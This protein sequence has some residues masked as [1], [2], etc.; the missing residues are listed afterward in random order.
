MR[1]AFARSVDRFDGGLL[2]A[3]LPDRPEYDF[4]RGDPRFKTLVAR[5]GLEGQRPSS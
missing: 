5:M 2:S 3:E 4:L 1:T